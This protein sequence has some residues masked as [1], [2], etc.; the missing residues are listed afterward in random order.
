[1]SP[2]V[3]QEVKKNLYNQALDNIQSW[4]NFFDRSHCTNDPPLVHQSP[5]LRCCVLTGG[6]H[7]P[8]H[9]NQRH[10]LRVLIGS[11]LAAGFLACLS[12]RS[13]PISWLLSDRLAYTRANCKPGL[14]EPADAA[15]H[16]A[17][18]YGALFCTHSVVPKA[19]R[20]NY[21]SCDKNKDMHRTAV[22][23]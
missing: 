18:V 2:H 4:E 12:Y 20:A 11:L 5:P 19:R 3:W 16:L 9:S 23:V 13:Q 21:T 6:S 8:E 17:C 10:W 14:I 7:T 1:M 22:N 15:R